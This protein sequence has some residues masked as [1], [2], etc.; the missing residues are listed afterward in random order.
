[1]YTTTPN[2]KV[3]CVKLF[4]LWYTIIIVTGIGVNSHIMC[5]S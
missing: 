1:M 3:K 2:P 5:V 4:Y